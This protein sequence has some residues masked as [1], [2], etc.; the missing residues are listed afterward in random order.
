[1]MMVNVQ[2]KTSQEREARAVS[3]TPPLSLFVCR[4]G[5]AGNVPVPVVRYPVGDGLAAGKLGT[6]TVG[7]Y[8]DLPVRTVVVGGYNILGPTVAWS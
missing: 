1:M 8:I 6:G 5:G 2:W 4:V 7:T 3:E